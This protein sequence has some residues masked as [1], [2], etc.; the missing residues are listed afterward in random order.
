MIKIIQKISPDEY[1]R[2]ERH[3]SAE[4]F[5][6]VSKILQD[7]K[8]NGDDAIRKYEREFDKAEIS[9]LRLSEDEISDALREVSSEY[10]S[11][12]QRAA[13]NIRDFHV[14]QLP[15]GFT[16]SPQ[17]G[18]ILGQRIIPIK[19]AGIYVPGGTAS[20]PSTVLMNTIPANVA[21]C[22]EVY[23]AT[24]PP[25]SPNIIAAA[26]IAG[27]TGIFRMGGAQAIGALAF[28]T[29]SV[30]KV[31]KITGP[32]NVY[33]AEAKRQVFGTVGIDI[34]AGPSEI[35]II[36]DNDNNPAY[37]AADML[38]Q[39][40]HDAYASAILIT[41]SARFARKVQSE[42]E[43]Q[44]S[45]LSRQSIAR[46]SIDNNSAIIITETLL[47]AVDLANDIAPE[48][49]Q[50]CIPEPL[51]WLDEIRNAGTVFI[52]SFSPEAAGDYVAGTNHTLPTMGT[53]R[54]ASPLSVNDFLKTSQFVYYDKDALYEV[55]EDIQMFAM[56]EG[57]QA[58]S[59]SI[60]IRSV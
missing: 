59:N 20:Y 56:S 16:Y 38:A 34:I 2:N 53:A 60:T 36:A 42:I 40:E 49:L 46:Q 31:D 4:I 26:H 41:T 17:E 25:V 58:H 23:I 14:H 6:T 18:V 8:E 30:P 28:G 29:Q 51:S 15:K 13:E 11:M 7:V 50:L 32:G 55:A 19:R 5:Q 45:A 12:L 3:I 47:D 10:S 9:E 22:E 21:G 52:G 37:I 33:V 24:P 57:L 44:I 27:V 35:L 39:A 54:F 1:K 48:H 43:R